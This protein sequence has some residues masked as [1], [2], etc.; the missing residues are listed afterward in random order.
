MY[1]R[2]LVMGAM[3][4]ASSVFAN[5]PKSVTLDVKN[6]TCDLCPV[7]IRKALQKT[8]GVTRAQIDFDKKTAVVS[9][10]AD[11]VNV[12]KLVSATTNA[13]FPSTPREAK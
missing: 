5:T 4:L 9:Y 3:L 10:D 11:T 7:T 6:M 13:G 1:S 2:I 12:A 8:P